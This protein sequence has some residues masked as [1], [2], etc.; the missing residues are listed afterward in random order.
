MSKYKKCY[1]H[2]APGE[3]GTENAF[4][5]A[6][7]Y[8]EESGYVMITGLEYNQ[9]DG[10][11]YFNF[12]DFAVTLNPQDKEAF[13]SYLAQ[14]VAK[15]FSSAWYDDLNEIL[16]EFAQDRLLQYLIDQMPVESRPE[17]LKMTCASC[18]HSF[19]GMVFHD[20]LGWHGVCPKCGASFDVDAIDVDATSRNAR[21]EVEEKNDGTVECTLCHHYIECDGNGDMPEFCPSC[22]S[23][24]AYSCYELSETATCPPVQETE[25]TFYV[26]FKLDARYIAEVRAKDAQEALQKAKSAYLDADFGA[27]EDINGEPIIVEDE[28]GDFVWEKQ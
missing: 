19:R 7:E 8:R 16:E 23:H 12:D 9:K 6:C 15:G 20:A 3:C 11:A 26:T 22:G 14:S 28:N 5:V 27:A 10:Y 25:E 21:V 4:Y 18:Y 13:M 1:H 24:L 2:C 17:G